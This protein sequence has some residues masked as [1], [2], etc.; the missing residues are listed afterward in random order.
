MESLVG[1]PASTPATGHRTVAAM[2]L[3]DPRKVGRMDESQTHGP[4]WLGSPVERLVP[5]PRARRCH[6]RKPTPFRYPQPMKDAIKR[7]REGRG[8]EIVLLESRSMSLAKGKLGAG[9]TGSVP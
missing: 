5:T 6:P 9:F 7:Q 2:G 8:D 4:P 3:R 1:E